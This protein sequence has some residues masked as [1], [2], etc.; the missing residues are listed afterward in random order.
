MRGVRLPT[1][2]DSLVKLLVFS[3]SKARGGCEEYFLS[4]ARGALARGWEVQACF[5]DVPGTRSIRDDLYL[6]G[7]KF[8]PWRPGESPDPEDWGGLEAQCR[9]AAGLLA[10]LAPDAALVALPWPDSAVGFLHHLA[11]Y[12]PGSVVSA[13]L[14]TEVV[15]I[16][17][18]L[19]RA[20]AG[21]GRL[22]WVAPS[23]ESASTLAATFGLGADEVR[24][25]PNGSVPDPRWAELTA[26]ERDA[27]RSEVRHELGVGPSHRLLVTAAR[28]TRQKGHSDLIRAAAPLVARHPQVVLAWA[29]E[30]E[31]EPDLRAE[32]R[33]AG[34]DGVVRF[35]GYRRDV[36]RLLVA[37]DLFVLPSLWE[38][39]PFAISEAMVYLCPVVASSLGA[40]RA[41]IG[42]GVAGLLH[43]LGDPDGLRSCLE[44]ALANPAAM[45][46]MAV[47]AKDRA[48]NLG[49]EMRQRTLDLLAAQATAG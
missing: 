40:N 47:R 3:P 10:A 4:L 28:L 30:G 46:Q 49:D 6:L 23:A 34:L 37:G 8:H 42:H 21:G 22:S 13:Q 39:M 25:I 36:P 38:G 2:A 16:P 32:V 41:L 29:G 27:I 31:D 17:P 26:Q 12:G 35:L 1:E 15:C 45:R 9:E 5:P 14:C 33:R 20:C 44:W 7:V 18:E 11:E 24:V 19:I 43:P 48:W